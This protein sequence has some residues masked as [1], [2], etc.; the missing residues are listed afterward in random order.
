MAIKIK[1]VKTRV[2]DVLTERE[3]SRDCDQKLFAL[4]LYQELI[5][6]A[7]NEPRL[8][9]TILSAQQ[10]LKIMSLNKMT[11]FESV[12]RAR[13]LLQAC[14]KD[15]NCKIEKKECKSQKYRGEKWEERKGY[16]S[17][18]KADVINFNAECEHIWI[19]ILDENNSHHC[20]SCKINKKR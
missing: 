5:E 8:D 3:D 6:K 16:E 13:A 7:K 4:I 14:P 1:D 18:V 20:R 11:N 15:C 2:K 17:H 10:L 12:R 19:P 9:P